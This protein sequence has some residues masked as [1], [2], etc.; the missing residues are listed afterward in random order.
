MPYDPA[1]PLLEIQPEKTIIQKDARTPMFTAALFP[2]AKT[3]KQP[4]CPM[5]DEQIKTWYIHTRE[6]YSAIK[7]MV[8]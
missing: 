7:K 4:N 5:T 1:I 3:W 8:K 6:Y 2:T